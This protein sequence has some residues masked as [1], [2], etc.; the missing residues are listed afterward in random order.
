MMQTTIPRPNVFNAPG[1]VEPR[2]AVWDVEGKQKLQHV[3]GINV[4][5]GLVIVARQ[6]VTP[7]ASGGITKY[8]L[9]FATIHPIY[10]G[11]KRP[12]LFHCYG[13]IA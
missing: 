10:G 1:A 4:R 9:K 12:C 2:C 11:G 6:P 8:A 13:R 3:T 7:T 5:K